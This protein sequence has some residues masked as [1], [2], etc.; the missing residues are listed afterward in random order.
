MT[1][2]LGKTDAYLGTAELRMG[3]VEARGVSKG[4]IEDS[5][6]SMKQSLTTVIVTGMTPG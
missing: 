3:R 2:S 4:K 1:V 6:S 5:I